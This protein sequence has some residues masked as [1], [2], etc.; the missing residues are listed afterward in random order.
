MIQE[1]RHRIHPLP[2]GW[3]SRD[4]HAAPASRNRWRLIHEGTEVVAANLRLKGAKQIGLFNV[5]IS[6][7]LHI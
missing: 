4:N 1:L 6:S 7:R 3:T 2:A 5:V